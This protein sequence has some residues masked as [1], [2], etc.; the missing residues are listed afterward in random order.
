M[1]H[2]RCHVQY[3]K[4]LVSVLRSNGHL[5][6]T[7]FDQGRLYTLDPLSHAPQV[8]LVASLPG[9]A[10]LCG[11][12]AIADDKF[13]IVGGVR[14]NYHYTN[15]TVYTVDFSTDAAN[16][17]IRAIARIPNASMLN[18]LSSMPNQPHII[19]MGDSQLGALFRVDTTTGE[20]KLA[21]KHELLVA[22]ANASLPIGVN[23]V[24][25]VGEYVLFTNSARNIFGRIQ[26]SA[27]GQRFGDVDDVA[28]LD[29]SSG[30][31]D[32]FIVDSAGVP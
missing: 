13:A 25:V 22:P 23:G 15:E 28:R 16:P 1:R 20:S 19:L 32:D 30:D 7:T 6:L 18:G 17:S 27:D 10:A 26:V 3:T 12:A 9:A 8:E 29:S 4:Y 5:L 31:W 21:L 2:G 14:G 11:I 24:Q